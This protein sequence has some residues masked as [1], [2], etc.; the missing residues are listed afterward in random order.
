MHETGLFPPELTS[1]VP[2]ITMT[3]QTLIHVEQHKGLM[4]YQENSI[5]LQTSLGALVICGEQLH[6]KQ[7]TASEAVLAGAFS[8]ISYGGK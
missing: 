7:Y 3:G 5:T 1:D 4:T 2:K 8:S 6:I